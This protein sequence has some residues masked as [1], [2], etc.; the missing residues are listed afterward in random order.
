MASRAPAP[1]DTET[2]TQ[3]EDQQRKQKKGKTAK[4]D[5][6]GS[7]SRI[8]IVP[9]D[10]PQCSHSLDL[11]AVSPCCI[12]MII[13]IMMM[14]MMMMMMMIIIIII[15]IFT[16]TTIIIIRAWEHVAHDDVRLSRKINKIKC[17]LSLGR[18]SGEYGRIRMREMCGKGRVFG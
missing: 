17:T 4:L 8:S 9:Y 18:V 7:D 6:V 10:I 5:E 2:N 13:M 16:I 11:W 3:E 15:I 1:G 12:I 14:M